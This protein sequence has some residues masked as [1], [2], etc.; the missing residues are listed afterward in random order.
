MSDTEFLNADELAE[1]TGYKYVSHQ[2]EWLNK[3]GWV[4]VLNAAGRPIVGRW[5]ARMRL[6]GV[7]PT[8]NTG[9]QSAWQPDFSSLK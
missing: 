2:R 5:Y 3:N 4:Y 7:K 9:I 6:S 8:A 1:V